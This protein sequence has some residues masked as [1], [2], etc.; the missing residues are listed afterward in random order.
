MVALAVFAAFAGAFFAAAFFAG[1]LPD[2]AFF[3]AAGAFLFPFKLRCSNSVRSIT[4]S[5]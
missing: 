2:A 5:A 4:L 1:A 3:A